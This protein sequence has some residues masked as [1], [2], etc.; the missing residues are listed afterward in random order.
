M[1]VDRTEAA[2]ADQWPSDCLTMWCALP[3]AGGW[4]PS[5]DW[6]SSCITDEHEHPRLQ[7]LALWNDNTHVPL[8]IFVGFCLWLHQLDGQWALHCGTFDKNK[9]RTTASGRMADDHVVILC[10]Q[11]DLLYFH[12][13][14][15]KQQVNGCFT[16][17]RLTPMEAYL[18]LFWNKFSLIFFLLFLL[19][20]VTFL[21]V[22]HAILQTFPGGQEQWLLFPSF[23][24]ICKPTASALENAVNKVTLVYLALLAKIGYLFTREILFF[25]FFCTFCR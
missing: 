19:R 4:G 10:V 11:K 16:P 17:Q 14:K 12:L 2:A 15:I 13:E 5:P 1:N 8:H 20:N 7:T 21:H 9:K 24:L 23:Y 6:L 18:L 25:C 22:C 3:T